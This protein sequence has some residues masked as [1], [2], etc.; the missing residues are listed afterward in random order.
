MVALELATDNLFRIIVP[1][2]LLLQSA[3][4]LQAKLGGL[5]DREVLHV[6]FSRRTPTDQQLMHAYGCL[7]NEVQL[8]NGIVLALPEHIL[9]FKLSGIQRLCDGKV[10]ESAVMIKIQDRFDRHAR[11]VLD[12]CDVTL[13]IRTQL[14]YPSGSQHTVDGHPLRWQTI[15]AL[16]DLVFSY[17]DDLVNRFPHSIEVVR[18]TGVSLF[19]FLR[20]DVEVYLLDQMVQKICRGQ[21]SILPLRHLPRRAQQ[22]IRSFITEPLVD[23]A[24]TSRVMAMFG[25]KQH[26][27]HVV[28]HLR[29]LVVYGILLS[30]LKKR[31]NVQY[32]LHPK[33]DPIAVPYQVRLL[34]T[35]SLMQLGYPHS[36]LL[37]H[38]RLKVSRHPPRSG[39]IRTSPSYSP[40]CHSTMKV[41]VWR[42]SSE[43]STS[44]QSQMNPVLSMVCGLRRVCPKRSRTTTA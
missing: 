37:I 43:R 19:Y 13:G 6:P 25:E 1:R 33:R 38:I 31:W 7:H 44:L 5:L 12:E 40:A 23:A 9:S 4:I 27:V 39:A 34:R 36:S 15:Q 8:R 18:R 32:G 2:P 30:T 28:L 21:T 29:G 11:D 35:M 42:N 20:D 14:I 17:L 22:D 3:Q 16:L 24:I 41:S 26:L 10:D